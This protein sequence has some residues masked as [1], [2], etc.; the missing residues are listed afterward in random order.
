[1][2]TKNKIIFKYYGKY[3]GLKT[4]I[5]F[6]GFTLFYMPVVGI[7]YEQAK[8]TILIDSISKNIEIF[9][10]WENVGQHFLPPVAELQG[11]SEKKG[12]GH[13]LYE[14]DKLIYKSTING[15]LVN[16]MEKEKEK[17]VKKTIKYL[18][19]KLSNDGFLYPLTEEF[20]IFKN[21]IK[22]HGYTST[23]A[24]LDRSE[25][26]KH[27]LPLCNFAKK[28]LETK[29]LVYK[30]FYS[31]EEDKIDFKAYDNERNLVVEITFEPGYPNDD[32]F[33]DLWQTIPKDE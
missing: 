26:T 27:F 23:W 7:D 28:I 6:I 25:I 20:K 12:Y 13:V 32:E 33:D 15:L 29:R 3:Q 31:F 5:L 24:L 9:N 2:L 30:V 14:Y 17:M 1:M 18:V 21:G 19:I 8:N 16:F 4:K 11:I 22:R 10:A